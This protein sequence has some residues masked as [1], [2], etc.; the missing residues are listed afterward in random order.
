MKWHVSLYF[1]LVS[2]HQYFA[3][4]LS[5]HFKAD[6]V[7]HTPLLPY[8]VGI[9]CKQFGKSAVKQLTIH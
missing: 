5:I 7:P 2:L 4:F 1:N 6:N 9:F 8:P 3:P